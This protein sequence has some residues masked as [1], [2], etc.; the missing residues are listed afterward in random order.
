MKK[1]NNLFLDITVHLLFVVLFIYAFAFYKERLF[2]D[3]GYYIYRVIDEK[4]FVIGLNRFVLFFSQIL[5][6]MAVKVGCC[7]KTI[8]VSYSINHVLFF[9]I[10]FLISRYIYKNR[11]A[12]ILLILVQTIGIQSAF[13][14]PM[15]ELYYGVGFLILFDVILNKKLHSRTDILLLI[16]LALIV[17]TSHPLTYFLFLFVLTFHFLIHRWKYISYYLVAIVLIIVVMVFKKYTA[18]EY[19]QGKTNSIF[20]LLHNGVYDRNYLGSLAI[21][22]FQYYRELL[23]LTA[24]TIIY[25]AIKKD[26]VKVILFPCSFLFFLA[27]LN[28][29]YY[30]FQHSR[31]QEAV[32]F[33]LFFV[34]SYTFVYYV[35]N[36]MEFKSAIIM[37]FLLI[38]LTI[39]RF[40]VI[41][42]EG[43]IFSERVEKM[44]ELVEYC[45]TLDGNKFIV[46]M[47]YLTHNSTAEVSWSYPMETMLLSGINPEKKTITI[48]TDDDMATNDNSSKLQP[49][50]YL[51][52]CWD[53]KDDK[54]VNQKYFHL[55]DTNYILLNK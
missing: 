52:R 42:N 51:M 11:L 28:L 30:G 31:Y 46:K 2:S 47:Q 39:S 23:L 19:E 18:S 14:S 5:P 1:I 8:L 53:I 45:R 27:L 50:N 10:L 41:K 12:G 3:S 32:Y 7:L 21:F 29:A 37:C 16:V 20:Y 49:E 35:L 26:F 55:K 36:G 34:V 24:I 6:V 38:G 4:G 43:I 48:C 54:S 25:F 13:F 22:L 17:L 40:I 15:F 44:E 33:P 9:Y